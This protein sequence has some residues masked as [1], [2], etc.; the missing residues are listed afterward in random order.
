MPPDDFWD[1]CREVSTILNNGPVVM[2]N[3]MKIVHHWWNH[4]KSPE[5]CAIHM[6][7][8]CQHDNVKE[9]SKC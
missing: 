9:H 2:F 5:Q 1:Y 8:T 4:G 6:L 7:K 3:N